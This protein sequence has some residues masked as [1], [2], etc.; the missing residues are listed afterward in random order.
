[1]KIAFNTVKTEN[2]NID[3]RRRMNVIFGLCYFH[4]VVLER[5]KFG[6]LGW[7]RNYPFNLDDLRNSDSV[8]AKYL[9]QNQG[10]SKIPWDDLRYIVGEIMYGGHI[11]DD[12]DRILNNAYL[13][14]LLVDKI[15]EDLDLIPYQSPNSTLKLSLKTPANNASFPFERW[16]EY[17]DITVNT[18]S[19][20]L[21]GL[22]PNAELDFRV[23]ET[24]TLFQNLIDLEPKDTSGGAGEETEGN[25]YDK[26]KSKCDD[27]TAKSGDGS[28]FNIAGLLNASGEERTPSQ[29][30]FIQE[31]EQMKNLCDLIKRNTNDIKD[32]IDGKLTMNEVIEALIDNL[33]AERVPAKWVDEGFATN[34]KL[35]DWIISLE[36][37]INQYKIF[38]SE[39]IIPKI[40]F[41]NRLFNPLSYLTAIRQSAARTGDSELDKLD[42]LTEPTAIDL[43]N[44]V[45]NLT[46]LPK[47][48]SGIVPIY[49]FHLQGA[50]WD[51]EN[52]NIEESRPREDYCIMPVI[53]CRVVDISQL[54]LTEKGFYICPV[55]KTTNRQNTYV[56]K[57]QFKTK[58]NPAKWIIA[59]VASILDVEK[60]DSINK[61]PK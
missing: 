5:K 32:A 7:N 36:L 12:W 58:Q 18:E 43:R 26:I 29:N 3:D 33:N 51:D 24:E 2:P 6:S 1:M 46:N 34:R 44:G 31:C 40:V 13:E 20:A 38:E 8:V 57:A 30:V 47:E 39:Q 17:I 53:N 49:G 50:R 4:S 60:T 23:R 28:S 42:I 41:I 45:E 56:T 15:N 25:K 21:F 61:Y 55:Y 14:F 35:A 10:S 9:D 48:G 27:I 37:R 59:G 11:V 19:P 22:H 16:A 52:R 54:K